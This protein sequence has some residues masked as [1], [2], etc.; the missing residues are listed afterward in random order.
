MP[1]TTGLWSWGLV[2]DT[3]A[4][5]WYAQVIVWL[6]LTVLMAV[7]YAVHQ[8]TR[9]G[10]DVSILDPVMA[11]IFTAAALVKVQLEKAAHPDRPQVAFFCDCVMYLIY[12]VCVLAM[13]MY[14]F[15]PLFYP[16]MRGKFPEI[17]SEVITELERALSRR[18]IFMCAAVL[19]NLDFDAFTDHLVFNEDVICQFMHAALYF[20]F[21]FLV[22]EVVDVY[23]IRN[24][25]L[26]EFSWTAVIMSSI[27]VWYHWRSL[28]INNFTAIP[29]NLVTFTIGVYVLS[30]MLVLFPG[31]DGDYV[32]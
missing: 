7:C 18:L 14:I 19:W 23:T 26:S 22:S 5:P 27:G 16:L 2:S 12:S 8:A 31:N 32:V 30:R 24:G 21:V 6:T 13:V 25:Y 15:Y 4:P 11:L 10:R 20:I 17:V 1:P 28:Y 9:V 3:V 29:W